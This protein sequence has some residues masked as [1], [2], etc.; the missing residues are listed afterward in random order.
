MAGKTILI[1]GAS[2]GI[3]KEV[4]MFFSDKGWNVA[5][6]MRAP[7]KEHELGRKAHVK[8]YKLDVTDPQMIKDTVSRIINDFGA[9]DVLVNNAGYGAVGIFETFTSEMISKQINTN[10]IG[11]MNVTKEVIPHMRNRQ[12]GSIINIASIG[13]KM[14]FPLYSIYHATKFAVEGFSESLSYEL[15]QFNIRVKIIEPGP[16]KTDF[17]SRSQDLAQVEVLP[18]YAEYFN[19]TYGNLQKSG[20]K[21]SHPKKVAR[22]IYEAALDKSPRLRYPIGGFAP[23][24]L[25]LRKYFSDERFMRL[26][27]KITER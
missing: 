8:L 5:A 11:L 4:A 6:T 18:E 14:A 21:G 25:F 7:E 19:R 26:V 2:S 1:T 9:I 16:I 17:Y 24:I 22:V 23:L 12:K 3:G 10:I 13:G 27:R 20:K 15:A